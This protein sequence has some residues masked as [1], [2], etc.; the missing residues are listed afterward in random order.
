MK[1]LLGVGAAALVAA[2][3]VL[4]L[5]QPPQDPPAQAPGSWEPAETST[6]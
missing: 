5:R 2:L 3:V 6:P 4:K 1:F